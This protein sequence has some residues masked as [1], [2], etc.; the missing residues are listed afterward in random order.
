MQ[1]DIQLR[2][3]GYPHYFQRPTLFPSIEHMAQTLRAGLHG[4][5]IHIPRDMIPP[6]NSI[7]F[8]YNSKFREQERLLGELQAE[9]RELRAHT[10]YLARHLPPG[11]PMRPFP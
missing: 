8:T 5:D 2:E 10:N 11:L 9:I 3:E 7:V 4:H 1:D 6:L